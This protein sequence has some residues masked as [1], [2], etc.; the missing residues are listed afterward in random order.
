MFDYNCTKF[1]YKCYNNK[2]YANFK[3]KLVMNS[4]I[5]SYNTRSKDALRKPRVKL[6]KFTN[7]FLYNGIDMWNDLPER[8]KLMN[9][10]DSFR[11]AV[12]TYIIGSTNS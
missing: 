5:H 6:H 7:S 3:N 12:K 8:I 10:F 11:I 2:N 4:D 9:S 1:I